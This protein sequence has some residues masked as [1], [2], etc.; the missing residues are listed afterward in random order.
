MEYNIL[1]TIDDGDS[2]YDDELTITTTK[3][4]EEIIEVIRKALAS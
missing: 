2:E 3:S 4:Q 1:I